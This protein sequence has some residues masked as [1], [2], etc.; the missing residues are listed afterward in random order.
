VTP[1]HSPRLLLVAYHFPPDSMIGAKRALRMAERLSD[2]GWDVRVLTIRE[3]FFDGLDESLGRGPGGRVVRTT[4]LSPTVWARRLRRALHRRTIAPG[5]NGGAPHS[6]AP[7]AGRQAPPRT[8]HW[9]WWRRFVAT[10]DEQS[11][12]IPPAVIAG[13]IRAPRPD[14]I[15]SSAPPF[16]AHVVAATL[17]RLRRVPLVLDYRDPWTTGAHAASF[18]DSGRVPTPRLEAWCVRRAAVALATTASIADTLRAFGPGRVTVVPNAMDEGITAG[19]EPARFRRFTILYAGTFYGSRSALPILR[20]L[21]EIKAAGMMPA[22]G[23][24]L[25]VMGIA[26]ADVRADAAALGV[27]DCLETEDFQ[28]YR[29]A[30][31]RMM[32]A[33]LLL[34]VVGET[35]GGMVPAKIFDYLAARRPILAIG[36]PG[37]EAGTILDEAGAGG[38]LAATDVAG[39]AARI[40]EAAANRGAP[41]PVAPERFTAAATMGALDRLLRELL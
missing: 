27:A 31:A 5:S 36:P 25:R 15:L 21:R 38:V 37:S 12:W 7:A 17:A 22:G 10:P 14:V 28:P 39:I 8:P 34:L 6:G 35:H 2:L 16:S 30:M 9:P 11:G 1:A 40:V 23:I 18:Q 13:W 32:G 3:P 4:T 33:D 29:Q 19:L 20:A 26:S 24:A 41:G